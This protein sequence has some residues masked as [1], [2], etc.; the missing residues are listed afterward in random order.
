MAR[1]TN[2]Q[3]ADKAAKMYE[4]ASALRSITAAQAFARNASAL[5]WHLALNAGD[6][7]KVAM[8][9]H[10]KEADK[11]AFVSMP[12]DDDEVA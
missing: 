8:S 10:A 4:E 12:K 11:L 2:Q 3:V 9:G 7:K 5:I 6:A 1:L